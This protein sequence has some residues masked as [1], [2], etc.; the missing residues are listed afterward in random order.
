MTRGFLTGLLLVM[1]MVGS[2]RAADGPPRPLELLP[3]ASRAI[4]HGASASRDTALLGYQL[5]PYSVLTAGTDLGLVAL[6]APWLSF[7]VGYFG[8]LE[9]ESSR[10]F[11]AA[12]KTFGPVLPIEDI[13]TWRGL[14]GLSFALSFDRLAR[15]HLGRRG[16]LEL[17]LSFRHESE[18]FT[19]TTDGDAPRDRDVP[20]IG[21]FVMPDLAAR[22]PLGRVDLE[23]RAQ[24]KVFLPVDTGRAN[25]RRRLYRLALGGD[26]V[27]RWRLLPGLHPFTSTFAEWVAGGFAP[28]DGGGEGRVP[29]AY[30]LRNLTGVI[31]P[32]RFGEIQL[33]TSLSVGHG[34]GL[35]V[36][37]E[38]LL[39]GW[40]VRVT[41]F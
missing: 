15:R 33:F 31:L 14:Q 4:S 21:D 40:G 22:I 8:M 16:A 13:D 38:E 28:L 35:H 19:G 12:G 27:V 29:D 23:L 39:L 20:H 1:A 3:G 36:F 7:R 2:A 10:P 26:A 17:A 25:G 34:K 30:L 6:R 32:G 24:E 41:P 5:T 11:R 9:I 37:R 18:H